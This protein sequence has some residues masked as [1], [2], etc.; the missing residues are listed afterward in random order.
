MAK[1]TRIPQINLNRT[2]AKGTARS[3]KVNPSNPMTKGQA[4]LLFFA[5]KELTG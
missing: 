3:L 1:A 5:V 2:V 4:R